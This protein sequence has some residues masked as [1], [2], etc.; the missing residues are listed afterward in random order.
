MKLSS[1]PMVTSTVTR[2]SM[3]LMMILMATV[4]LMLTI[5]AGQQSAAILV[6]VIDDGDAEG[7]ETVA[8][9]LT[10]PYAGPGGAKTATLLIADNEAPPL[11]TVTIEAEAA[12]T[13]TG[14]YMG[15][16]EAI[17]GASGGR[18]L[19]FVGG[20]SDEI[21]SASVVF[22]DSPDELAGIYD[23]LLGTYDENDG[24]ASFTAE[25]TDFETGVTTEIGSLLLDGSLGS[26]L[27]NAQ[28]AISPT[29]ATDIS[30]TAGDL[31][32]IN[33]FEQGGRTRA[34]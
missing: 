26:N 18:V 6:N 4:P 32:T 31:I 5:A 16:I 7:A 9:T 34:T 15:A 12:D 33:A 17:G 20:A 27:A 29:I 19:S 23:I 21:G 3:Q 28:T 8:V 2:Y 14:D 1:A 11:S 30:L 25:L 22:G 13:I 10:G 24:L